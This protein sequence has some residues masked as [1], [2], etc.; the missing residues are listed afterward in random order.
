VSWQNSLPHHPHILLDGQQR[1]GI[2]EVHAYEVLHPT[3][4]LSGPLGSQRP[5]PLPHKHDAAQR[6]STHEEYV[7]FF[8]RHLCL[9]R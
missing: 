6:S 1:T 8:T 4:L 7:L 5:F 2:N 9:Q 3:I